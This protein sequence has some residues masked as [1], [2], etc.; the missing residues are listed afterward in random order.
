MNRA[1]QATI[2]LASRGSTAVRPEAAEDAHA[3]RRAGDDTQVIAVGVP[4]TNTPCVIAGED[5]VAQT[6]AP[7]G[8]DVQQL[9]A[10]TA[11]P[12]TSVVL[13]GPNLVADTTA[14]N[15]GVGGDDV[16]LVA[17]GV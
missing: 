12:N 5:G 14:N 16:Q 3:H 15:T 6:P 4:P 1:A 11:A 8:D 9:A 2:L 7:A 10:G 17:V 13:C